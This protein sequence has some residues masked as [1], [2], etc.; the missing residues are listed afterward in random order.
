MAA[1]VV[2]NIV[3]EEGHIAKLS[4]RMHHWGVTRHLNNAAALP[5][6]DDAALE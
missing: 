6:T 5:E 4:S 3:I 2:L 1:V